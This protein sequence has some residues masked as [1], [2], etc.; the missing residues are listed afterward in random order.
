MSEAVSSASPRSAVFDP[1]EQEKNDPGHFERQGDY[2]DPRASLVHDDGVPPGRRADAAGPDT[3]ETD[4][5]APGARRAPP[6]D[7]DYLAWREAE[8]RSLDEAYQAWRQDQARAY[9]AAYQTWRDAPGQTS[10]AQ[11]REA[12]SANRASRRPWSR[13]P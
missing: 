4:P 6:A 13:R 12:A 9:D 2:D 1:A 5:R 10:F 7:P 11:W 3:R 8:L